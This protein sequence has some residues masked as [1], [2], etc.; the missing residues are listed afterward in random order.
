MIGT[1]RRYQKWIWGA[2]I[3]VTIV[4]FVAYFNPSSRYGGGMG[5][6]SSG[7]PDLGS[8]NGEAVTPDQLMAAEREAVLATYLHTGTWPNFDE[9]KPQL[10]RMAEQS[11][12]MQSLMKEYKVN[13]TTDAAARYAKELFRVPA[14][15]AFPLDKFNDWIQNELIRKGGLSGEDFDRFARHQAGQECLLALFGMSGQLITSKEAEFFYRREN[16]PMVTEIVAFPTTNFYGATAPT[17][18]DLQDY[19]AKHEADYRLPD[20][21]QINYIALNPS[22]YSAQ[23]DK[24]LGTNVDERVDSIYHQ[25]GPDFFKDES[26]QLLSLAAAQAK[27]KQQLRHITELQEARKDANAL[28][29]ALSEGH[30]ETHPFAPSDL[31]KL[32]KAKGLVVKTTEPFD[33]KDGTKDL[34]MPPRGLHLLFSLR[35]DAPDDPGRTMLY[36]SSPLV[37]EDAVYVAGLQQRIP[38]QLQTLAAVREKVVKDYR[39]SKALAL[40]GEAGGKFAEA[41]HVGLMQGQSFDAICA[42]QNVKPQ[43]LPYFALTTTNVPS[44]LDKPSFQQLQEAVFPLPT[45]QSTKFIPI[46]DGGLVAYVKERLPVDEVRMK[47]EL[48]YYLTRMREQRQSAAFNIWFGRQYQLRWVPPASAQSSTG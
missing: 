30:D 13:P 16:Q 1:I 26:G 45:G 21:V 35:A 3:T 15:Q 2:V 40:A 29:L 6:A 17:D 22:N 8:I 23:A 5:A 28:L 27:I 42:A 33:E 38:S 48:P 32:A 47:E 37:T 39:E 14:E 44:G 19:F 12:V 4:S 9:Q 31:E 7:G 20:R 25:Q 10:R 34:D 41:L 18:A 11:L 24:I 46:T 36:V 43:S